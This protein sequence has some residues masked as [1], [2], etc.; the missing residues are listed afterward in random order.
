MRADFIKQEPV[1][2]KAVLSY[3][4]LPLPPKAPPS[5]TDYDRL[6]PKRD[7]ATTSKA[8]AHSPRPLPVYYLEDDIR[9]QF[10]RDHPFE[11]FRPTTLV[12]GAGIAD[13]HPI[14]G[15]AW[16]RLR[17]RGRNPTPEE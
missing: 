17:Q 4:P 15:E 8:N 9:R 16:T 10:F 7:S 1:W 2:Y 13:P 12:E 3:P 5:R 6:P 11:A 14:Q